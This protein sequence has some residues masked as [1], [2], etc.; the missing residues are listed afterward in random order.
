MY[1][2]SHAHLDDHKF[3]PDREAAIQRAFDAG[4]DWIIQIG[5]DIKSS[6]FSIKL[7]EQYPHIYATVSIH[8]HDAKSFTEENYLT[9]R[10]LAKHPKVIAIGEIG[11]DYHYDFSPR[12]IQLTTFRRL[13]ELAADLKKPVVI[14]SREA[15]TETMQVLTEFKDKVKGVLHC[16]SGDEKMLKESIHLGYYISIAGPVTYP[17][18]TRMQELVKKIPMPRLLIETDCP[19]LSPQSHRGKRNEPSYVIE[20]AAKIGELRGFSATDIGRNTAINAKTL[21]GIPIPDEP[22]I[23]Y[24]TRNSLYLNITNRCTNNCYF[25]VRSYTDYIVGHNLRLKKEPTV[26]E[27]IAA[28]GDPK[29]YKEI[30]FCGYGEPTL[31]LEVIKSVAKWLKEQGV[32]VRLDT[33]GHG[34]IINKRNIVPELKGLIDAVSVSLDA[35]T[36]EQYNRICRPVFGDTTFQQVIEFIQECKKLLPEVGITVVGV[37]EV[38]EQQCRNLANELGVKFRFRVYNEVG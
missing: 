16:F 3:D 20:T 9:L 4:V 17:K 34:N 25:C 23:A 10:E 24:Q 33:N 18:S 12:D 32:I 37:P 19:Y 8:P 27:I 29:R 6:E 11:L 28:I 35:E 22:S 21:F 2:D 5:T 13:M 30:V 14:H 26:E 1:I 7:A 31:R 36:A 15:D 38:N